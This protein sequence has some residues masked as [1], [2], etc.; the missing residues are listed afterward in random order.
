MQIVLPVGYQLVLVMNQFWQFFY[1]INLGTTTFILG[2][3]FKDN[4]FSQSKFWNCK[5]IIFY[6]NF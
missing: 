4:Q 1:A 6:F 3:L 2:L 5:I